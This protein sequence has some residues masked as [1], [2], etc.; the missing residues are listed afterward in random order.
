MEALRRVAAPQLVVRV[1][2]RVLDCPR[3]GR[4]AGQVRG[5]VTAAEE[6]ERVSRD[7]HGIVRDL[8]TPLELPDRRPVLHVRK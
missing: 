1:P 3:P 7:E 6:V 2:D 5:D 8:A 4:A